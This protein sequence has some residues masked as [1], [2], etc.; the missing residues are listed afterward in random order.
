MNCLPVLH[1]ISVS[2][3]QVYVWEA[4]CL[5]HQYTGLKLQ[6]QNKINYDWRGVRSWMQMPGE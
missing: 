2:G 4:L 3:V 6:G 5:E 1:F